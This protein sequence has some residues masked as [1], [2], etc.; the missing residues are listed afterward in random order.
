MEFFWSF[1]AGAAL[2]F[3]GAYV[4]WHFVEHRFT[5]ISPGRVYTSGAMPPKVLRKT[6]RRHGIRAVFDLRCDVEGE[7]KIAAEKAA[8][9]AEGVAHVNLQSPQVPPAELRDRFVS[10]IG[11]AAHRPALIHCNHGEGRALLYGALWRIEFEGICLL[12]TS[13]SP[14]DRQK[15]RMPS[16]A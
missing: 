6:V 8:L 13:P 2:L 10:T 5:V 4:W 16:S 15:S 11:D 7:E 3:G 14:R 12:Y 1:L 9:E